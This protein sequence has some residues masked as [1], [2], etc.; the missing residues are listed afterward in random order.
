MLRRIQGRSHLH[1][2]KHT[3]RSPPG[4]LASA[5]SSAPGSEGLGATI[6]TAATQT[7]FPRFVHNFTN[8]LHGNVLSGAKRSALLEQ[9]EACLGEHPLL[10]G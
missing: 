2:L 4:I 8:R 3:N 5:D 7:T 9:Y 1:E 6:T 10:R